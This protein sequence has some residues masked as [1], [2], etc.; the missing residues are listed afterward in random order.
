MCC[1]EDEEV[2]PSYTIQMGDVWSAFCIAPNSNK[3]NTWEKEINRSL[4]YWSQWMQ[5]Y[6]YYR[7][8]KIWWVTQAL[9]NKTKHE[10]ASAQ[11]MYSKSS[12]S[13]GFFNSWFYF[14]LFFIKKYIQENSS[15]KLDLRVLIFSFQPTG[16]LNLLS[17]R[18]GTVPSSPFSA[19]IQL[20]GSM[21]PQGRGNASFPQLRLSVSG[22]NSALM[23]KKTV[24]LK[25]HRSGQLTYITENQFRKS[26]FIFSQPEPDLRPTFTPYQPC[27]TRKV[28]YRTK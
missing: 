2:H 1:S 24:Q 25:S 28:V 23:I 7:E 12:T 9:I 27:S 5:R 16:Y 22:S 11:S 21:L 19:N 6:S 4:W 15:L 17:P 14:L 8:T 10:Y 20:T 26:A 3:T 13:E 18:N